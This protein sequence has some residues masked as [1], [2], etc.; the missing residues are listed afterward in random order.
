MC[1]RGVEYL[2]NHCAVPLQ[3][4]PHVAVSFSV[5]SGIAATVETVALVDSGSALTLMSAA[6]GRRLSLSVQPVPAATQCL[7]MLGETRSAGL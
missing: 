5:S 4:R 3:G 6:L 2:Y 1:W 7:A